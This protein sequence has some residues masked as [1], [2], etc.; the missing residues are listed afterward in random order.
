M[1]ALLN[2]ATTRILAVFRAEAPVAAHD[3]EAA[4][5]FVPM[6]HRPSSKP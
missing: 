6:A 3:E 2:D 4:L 1:D 5:I